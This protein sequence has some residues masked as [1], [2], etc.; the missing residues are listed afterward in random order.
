MSPTSPFL[1]T[2]EVAVRLRCSLRTVHELTRQGAL[3]PQRGGQNLTHWAM[4][5]RARSTTRVCM[6]MFPD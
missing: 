3:A 4:P 6:C 2:S 1:I 5:V